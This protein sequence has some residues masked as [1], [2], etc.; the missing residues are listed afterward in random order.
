MGMG[1]DVWSELDSLLNKHDVAGVASVYASDI[2][3][4]DPTGRYEGRDAIQ[5]Y[6]EA[7][8]KAIPDGKNETVRLI[9]EGDTVVAEMTYR[10]THSGP[11]TMPDGTEVPASGNAVEL[12]CV[13]IV[14]VRDGKIVS[15]RDY[16]DLADMM[17]Q[18]GLMPG[19]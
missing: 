5:A 1:K 4:V 15:E 6:L 16:F 14:T 9:E 3:L 2:V 8:D 17:S 18:L 11:F 7:G 12:H 10:G 19:T 13:A